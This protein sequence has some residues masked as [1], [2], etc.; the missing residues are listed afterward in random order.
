MGSF[1]GVFVNTQPSH[2][3]RR[4][5]YI[6]SYVAFVDYM[7]YNTDDLVDE[8]GNSVGEVKIGVGTRL[9]A[10][11]NTKKRGIDLG[12]ILKIGFAASRNE[13]TGTLRIKILGVAGEMDLPGAD[14]FASVSEDAIMGALQK[15]AI[16]NNEMRDDSLH[17]R[18]QILAIRPAESFV[19]SIEANFRP[20]ADLTQ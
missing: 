2:L 9:I 16:V 5:P 14:S 15:I 3:G 19:Q 13:L 18:P 12:S 6:G 7:R 4:S 11:V 17:W 1:S 8:S 10:H 20:P